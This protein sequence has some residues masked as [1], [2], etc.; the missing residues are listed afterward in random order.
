VSGAKV[1]GRQ[2]PDEPADDPGTVDARALPSDRDATPDPDQVRAA[3]EAVLR[4]HRRPPGFCVPN[5]TSYPWQWLW[6]SCFHAVCWARLDQ[7]DRARLELA[8]ALSQQAADGFVAH[9]TY[10]SAGGQADDD[11]HAE[12]WGRR[13]TSSITQP[14]MYGHAV[15]ELVRIGVDVGADLV[16]RATRGLWFLLQARRRDGVGPVIVHPWESGCDDSPRW[17]AWDPQGGARGRAERWR[18]VK[19]QL[20]E[21]VVPAPGGSPVASRAFEVA[22]A[23]FTAL[24][25][26]NASELAGVTGDAALAAAAQELA[27]QLDGR[28]SVE[29]G[30]WTDRVVVGGTESAGSRTVEALL[31][32]LVSSDR[33]AIDSAFA[34]LADPAHFGARFGPTGVHRDEPTFDPRTYWRGPAWP[35]L[36][37][38]LW[39]AAARRGREDDARR[40]AGALVAGAQRSGFAEYWDPD[41]GEGL[42]AVPQSWTALAVMV[43]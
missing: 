33:S 28:W 43:I 35:Q 30:T 20:V 18:V 38:L 4:G 36:T 24:L 11:T 9:M 41:T 19:G 1:S 13:A 23:G 29:A 39:L 5:S 12:F 31:A 37:Y 10:W 2:P 40:L 27:V 17:D 8:N 26:F 6:D 21:S 34:Q 22:A 42:G 15:A 25:A 32:V 14:P 7:P 16:E 3:A